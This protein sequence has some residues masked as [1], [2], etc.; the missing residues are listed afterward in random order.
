[1]PSYKSQSIGLQG[2]SIN[3]F[4]YDDNLAFNHIK[5]NITV[6]PLNSGHLRVL[7]N[8]SVTKRYPLLGGSLTKIAIFGTKHFVRYTRHVRYLGC[9]LLAVFTVF[10]IEK[11]NLRDRYRLLVYIHSFTP[12]SQK[13]FNE[14]FKT[15]SLDWKQ[16]YLPAR[17]VTLDSYFCS[18]QYKILNIVLY[19]N[20][21]LL[22]T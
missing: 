10:S 21:K 17:F 6:K 5:N 13:Y 2:K 14:L 18:V 22:K 4:L 15:K 19:W 8:V 1:M 9:L 7:K 11:L 20:E 3:C 16:I 12:T